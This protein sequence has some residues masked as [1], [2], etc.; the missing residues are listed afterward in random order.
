M[1][2]ILFK[3]FIEHKLFTAMGG[4]ALIKVAN[5]ALGFALSV[6]LARALNADGFGIY[7]FI[8]AL[9][10]LITIPAKMGI[11]EVLIRETSKA[12]ADSDWALLKGLWQWSG[13]SVA[14]TS[15]VTLCCCVAIYAFLD[16]SLLSLEHVKSTFFWGLVLIPFTAL[17]SLRGSILIGLHHV[18]KG[19]LP[20]GVLRPLLLIILILLNVVFLPYRMTPDVAM[21]FHVVASAFAYL[22][23]FYLLYKAIPLYL[24]K[25]TRRTRRIKQWTWSAVPLGLI[26]GIYI[27]NQQIDILLLGVLGTAADVGIYKVIS[28]MG[29]FVIFGQQMVRMAVSPYFA[30]HWHKKE[31]AELQAIVNISTKVSFAIAAVSCLIFFAFGSW[32]LGAVFGEE[33]SSGYYA[34]VI[35]CFGQLINASFG[36]VGN[37]LNM[38]NN[39]KYSLIGL[40]FS[41]FLNI[42]L[43]ILF[44]PLWGINGAAIS[45][46]VS[47]LVWNLFLWYAVR[48]RLDL[49]PSIFNI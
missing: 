2:Y 46:S 31:F 41:T 40:T 25:E 19:Q 38:T 28:Q 1:R 5:I 13:F 39:E 14:V 16:D 6:L 10:T 29:L 18:F 47:I 37:L 34:M 43:N 35:L 24:R 45:T 8:F 30:S 26:S 32:M 44:I 4:S 3:N 15:V 33:Y 9:V 11:P 21:F 42:G 17:V 23:G 27:I 22:S 48:T 49:K 36:P 12:Y 20:D 7:S